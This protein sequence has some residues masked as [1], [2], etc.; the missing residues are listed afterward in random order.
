MWPIISV[1][2]QV[3]KDFKVCITIVL[4]LV[5]MKTIKRKGKIEFLTEK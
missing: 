3:K 4:H 2:P 5:D 1:K